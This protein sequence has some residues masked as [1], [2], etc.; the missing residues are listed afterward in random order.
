MDAR[1]ARPLLGAEGPAAVRVNGQWVAIVNPAAG[2]RRPAGPAASR[3][4]DDL[5]GI[6]DAVVTTEDRGHATHL[7]STFEGADGF[8]VV[9]GDGTL[10]D[11]LQSLCRNRQEVLIVPTGRGNS[12]ARDLDIRSPEA[13][14]TAAVSGRSVTIDLLAVSLTFEDGQRWQGVS[15]STLALGY[16]AGVAHLATSRWRW[17][18]RHCYAIAAPL[19]RP[20]AMGMQVSYDGEPSAWRSRTGLIISNT[21]HIGPF[22]A[23]PEA[24]LNDGLCDVM[25]LQ[26]GWCVQN[27]HNLSVLTGWHRFRPAAVRRAHTIGVDM[28]V[29]AVVKLDGELRPGVRRVEVSVLPA[30]LE[31][32]IPGGAHG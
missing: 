18:G 28:D 20:S 25:E 11:V 21:R 32:R 22:E 23:F 7:T 29:P 5:A 19:V 1:R 16:P 4:V 8:I 27:L 12:L 26:A 31:C 17:S 24:V 6:A 14:L 13:A 3:W 30:A 2:G 10:F 9:G 15:A